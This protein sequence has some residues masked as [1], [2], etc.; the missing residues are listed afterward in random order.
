MKTLSFYARRA[1]AALGTMSA[2]SVRK[3]SRQP[4]RR[5]IRR[6]QR[7]PHP[8]RG[9]GWRGKAA[10]RH[11]ARPRSCRANV[12]SSRDAIHVEVSRA[13]H[14]HAR[15]RRLGLGSEGTLSRRGSR[16]RSR[17]R[18]EQLGLRNLVLWGNSTGGR[19]VQVFAGKHPDLVSRVISE[20]VGPE[21]PRQ[22]ADNY[23]KRVQ[24]EQAGW[25]SEEELLAQLK[26][27][28]PRMSP[29]VLEPYV[30]YGT[31]KRADGRIEWKRDPQ[32]VNGFVAT[33]CGASCATSSRPSSTSSVAAA[34]S[35]RRRR[36]TNWED[37]AERAADH[38]SR[39]RPLP[40]RREAVKV[41]FAAGDS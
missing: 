8:L 24:Q 34:T 9:L 7:S 27:T 4:N 25:A 23:A 28:N 13:R 20:D 12:R 38:C 2:S 18:G 17:G 40:E 19:V 14:R 33:D 6:R 3:V 11:G 21:R 1:R 10:A 5:S 39:R 32:L 36:R 15:P 35:C 26:K 30:R 31:K 41:M 22:I 16:R 37:A 29:A